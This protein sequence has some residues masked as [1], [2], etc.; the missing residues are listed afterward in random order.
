MLGM[1]TL[2]QTLLGVLLLVSSIVQW[3]SQVKAIQSLVISQNRYKLKGKPSIP[4]LQDT[5]GSHGAEINSLS[6]DL[7]D[8]LDSEEIFFNQRSRV[9]WLKEGDR[10]TKFFHFRAFERKRKNT[11][12]GI[13][14]ENG[15]WCD[16]NDTIVGVV[17][18]YF[19]KI[20]TSS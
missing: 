8:L 18:Q 9:Q 10:N 2:T 15:N 3:I 11:I 6:K 13:W 4:F 1:P 20:Y 17:V 16:T 12:L 14:D 19:K 5:N 7:N